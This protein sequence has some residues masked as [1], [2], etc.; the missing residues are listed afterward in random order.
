MARAKVDLD[1]GEQK[2]ASGQGVDARTRYTKILAVVAVVVAISVLGYN[3]RPQPTGVVV[4]PT[5][6]DPAAAAPASPEQAAQQ[7]RM[8]LSERK[9][10]ADGKKE[11]RGVGA[12]YLTDKDGTV[13]KDPDAP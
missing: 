1:K 11:V 13:P 2:K 5:T 10:N 6:S 4:V 3:L 9:L 8:Q 12:R 7:N